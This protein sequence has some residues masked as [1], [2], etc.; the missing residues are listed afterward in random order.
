RDDHHVAFVLHAHLTRLM[1]ARRELA[2]DRRRGGDEI[3]RR[4]MPVRE[5]EH[6]RGEL[7]AIVAVLARDVA[8][9]LEAREHAEDLVAR[10]TESGRD[11]AQRRTALRAGEE[12]EDVETLFERG[13]AV[14]VRLARIS[15]AV[16]VRPRSE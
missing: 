9:F 16:H 12:L 7:E 3:L 1:G 13:R 11:L 14:G 6:A 5:L 2:H 4:R 10:A 15:A 8:A